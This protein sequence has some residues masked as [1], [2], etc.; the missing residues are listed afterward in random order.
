M[1]PYSLHCTDREKEQKLVNDKNIIDKFDEYLTQKRL[2]L[3]WKKN[4]SETKQKWVWKALEKWSHFW[5]ALR[6]KFDTKFDFDCSE[7]GP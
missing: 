2:W 4:G 5:V 6:A 3:L 1:L 7:K